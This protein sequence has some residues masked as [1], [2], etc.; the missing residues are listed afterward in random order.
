LYLNFYWCWN[1]QK[2][3]ELKDASLEKVFLLI[4]WSINFILLSVLLSL[5]KVNLLFNWQLLISAII[6]FFLSGKLFK[7]YYTTDKKLNIIDKNNEPGNVKYLVFILVIL[8]T[9]GLVFSSF[10]L[11]RYILE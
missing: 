1:T 2:G 11:G 9:T 3:G 8:G 6:S 10:F 7:K 5:L 4:L